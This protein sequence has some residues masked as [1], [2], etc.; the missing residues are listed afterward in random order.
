MSFTKRCSLSIVSYSSAAI[1]RNPIK[2]GDDPQPSAPD[3]DSPGLANE[4]HL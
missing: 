1:P 4:T 3:L 2:T